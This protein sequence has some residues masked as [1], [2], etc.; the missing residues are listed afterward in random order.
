MKTS[1]NKKNQ[2]FIICPYMPHSISAHNSYTLLSL[3][4][5]KNIAAHYSSDKIRHNIMTLLRNA[6][7]TEKI[8]QYQILQLLDCLNSFATYTDWHSE[9][10]NPFINSLIK[11]LELYPEAKFSIEEMAQNLNCK[12]LRNKKQSQ[13]AVRDSHLLLALRSF[14][15]VLGA[16]VPN[17]RIWITKFSDW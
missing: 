6:L 10:Q 17:K 16:N 1:A 11:Q 8:N 12:I 14:Y 9:S 3:C 13:Q 2:T 4:I 7:N 5:D 15:G